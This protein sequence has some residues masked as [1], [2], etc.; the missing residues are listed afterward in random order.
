MV[1]KDGFSKNK[2]KSIRTRRNKIV[3]ILAKS[4][5]RNLFKTR[6]KIL[7]QLKKILKL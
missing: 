5:I 6:S 4:K 7:F 1:E 2:Y 3:E